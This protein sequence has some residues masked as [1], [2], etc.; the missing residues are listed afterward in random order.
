[1]PL[2]TVTTRAGVLSKEAKAKFANE[3]T[4]FHSEYAA[5]PGNWAHIVF[6]R[7]YPFRTMHPEAA[8]RPGRPLQPRRLRRSFEAADRRTT[9]AAC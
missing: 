5:V 2:Y 1:M 7:L 3:L 8:L 6:N 9:S 4:K